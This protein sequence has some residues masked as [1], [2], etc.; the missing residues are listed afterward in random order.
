[1][2]SILNQEEKQDVHLVGNSSSSIHMTSAAEVAVT[3]VILEAVAG[4]TGDHAVTAATLLSVVAV[5]AATLPAAV[6]DL[7]VSAATATTTTTNDDSNKNKEDTILLVPPIIDKLS[8]EQEVEE[9]KGM[10]N[11]QVIY[12][13]LLGVLID[14]FCCR[15]CYSCLFAAALLLFLQVIL[16]VLAR[17]R[18]GGNYSRSK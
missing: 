18:R 17:W 7:L 16:F 9:T 3:N 14:D 8:K 11:I 10:T 5:G 12:C 4:S 6:A 1:M 2:I 13:L 15:V